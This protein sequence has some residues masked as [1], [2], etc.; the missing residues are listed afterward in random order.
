MKTKECYWLPIVLEYNAA[1]TVVENYLIGHP[2]SHLE[3]LS[4]IYIIAI[5]ALYVKLIV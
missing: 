3:Y 1:Y 4:L 2:Y 5:I